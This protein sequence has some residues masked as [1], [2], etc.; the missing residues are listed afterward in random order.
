MHKS[1]TKCNKTLGK[2][3]KNKHGPSKIIDTFETYQ[4]R[5]RQDPAVLELHGEVLLVGFNGDGVLDGVQ[6]FTARS[7]VWSSISE[8]SCKY[9]EERLEVSG[10]SARRGARQ[11]SAR[12]RRSGKR[13]S[14]Q[15]FQ[16]DEAGLVARFAR[17]RCPG[18]SAI[19]RRSSRL[20][21]ARSDRGCARRSGA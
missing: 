2:W 12:V 16:E 14:Y 13:H 7:R 11:R 1:A 19:S 21:A 9:A 18:A 4:R 6:E 17:S 10:A 8:A 5:R 15:E 3:C 20:A